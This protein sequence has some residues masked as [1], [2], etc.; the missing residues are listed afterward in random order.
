M[1]Q[2]TWPTKKVT[3]PISARGVTVHFRKREPLSYRQYR[4]NRQVF[5]PGP[6]PNRVMLNVNYHFEKKQ[7]GEGG[8]LAG[9]AGVYWL[10]G[11]Q[12]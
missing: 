5:F 10:V 9:V 7:K 11:D 3:I 12:R 6:S 1:D 4:Q 8:W 2:R